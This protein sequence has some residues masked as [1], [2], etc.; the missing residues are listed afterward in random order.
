MVRTVNYIVVHCSATTPQQKW[1]VAEITRVHK[2][3]GF[4]TIGYHFVI[5]R[6]GVV[7]PGR[8]LEVAGAHVYGHNADSVGV[9]LVGGI[10]ENGKS[11]N[12]F[13]NAQ[14]DALAFTVS[15]LTKQFRGAVVKGHRDFPKVAKDCPCFNVKQWW[16]AVQKGEKNEQQRGFEE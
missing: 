2:Q 11:T 13:T 14:W 6:D 5:R 16:S 9:C 7:E 3:R 8:P 10:D 12:N 1:G 4:K 15:G